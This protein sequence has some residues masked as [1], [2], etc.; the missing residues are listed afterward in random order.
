M[1]QCIIQWIGYLVE[2]AKGETSLT[3]AATEAQAGLSSQL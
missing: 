1:Y 3:V 2:M